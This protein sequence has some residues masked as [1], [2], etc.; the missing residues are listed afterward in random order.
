M[1]DDKT[2]TEV[3]AA[4]LSAIMSLIEIL[5]SE[6]TTKEE[7]IARLFEFQYREF[8]K[9]QMFAS[10]GIMEHLRLYT[11]DPNRKEGRRQ[12]LKFLQSPPQGS[13]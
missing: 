5:V 4:L 12:F 11:L 9:K 1:I 2:I 3:D 6:K 10:A 7:N 8:Y 13:A